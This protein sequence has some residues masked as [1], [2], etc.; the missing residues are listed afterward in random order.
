MALPDRFN[1][2]PIVAAA[3]ADICVRECGA[4]DDRTEEHNTGNGHRAI[5]NWLLE[6]A[7]GGEFRFVG[8]LGFGGKLYVQYSDGV[9]RVSCYAEDETPARLEAMTT[10]QGQLNDLYARRPLRTLLQAE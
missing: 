6:G 7:P 8:S 10:A 3:T 1:F 9:P 5:A 4:H 2:D